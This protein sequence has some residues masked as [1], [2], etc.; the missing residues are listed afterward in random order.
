MN[1]VDGLVRIDLE[2]SNPALY[3]GDRV[4]EYE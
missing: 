1:H 2:K 4:R 3:Y